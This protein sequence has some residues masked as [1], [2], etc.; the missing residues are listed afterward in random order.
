MLGNG[1][2][3]DLT[4]PQLSKSY[5]LKL[6]DWVDSFENQ[7]KTLKLPEFWLKI[8]FNKLRDCVVSAGMIF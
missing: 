4:L 7:I 3:Q 5:N 8:I 1:T 6:L 2:V